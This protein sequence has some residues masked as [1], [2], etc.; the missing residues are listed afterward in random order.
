VTTAAG[1]EVG[2]GS[3]SGAWRLRRCLGADPAC[4][5]V[6]LIA[7]ISVNDLLCSRQICA[8]QICYG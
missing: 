8:E 5:G 7:G 4:F 3:V 2:E 6:G 1:L